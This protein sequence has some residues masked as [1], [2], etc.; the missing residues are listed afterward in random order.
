MKIVQRTIIPSNVSVALVKCESLSTPNYTHV[1]VCETLYGSCEL[2]VLSHSEGFDI[3]ISQQFHDVAKLIDVPRLVNYVVDMVYSRIT[4]DEN[5]FRVKFVVENVGTN[6]LIKWEKA[7]NKWNN[8][9]HET[10]AKL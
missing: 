10:R 7:I 6:A 1:L 2:A 5:Q 3:F 8:T 4:A 9:Y